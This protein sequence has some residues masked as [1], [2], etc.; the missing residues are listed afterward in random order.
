M[1]DLHTS[2]FDYHLPEELI[3]DHP[4]DRRDEARLIHLLREDQSIRHVHIFDLPSLLRPGDLLVVNDT[5]VIPAR[6][7]GRRAPGGGRVEVLLVRPHAPTTTE[8][9]G[10]SISR[11][12]ALVRPGKKIRPGD[13]LVFD[14]DRLEA[15]VAGFAEGPGA[16]LLDFCWHGDSWDEVLEAIGKT[17]LPPYILRR[18]QKGH[19]T[20]PWD[21]DLTTAEDRERYQTVYAR[22]SG[23]V[24]APTAGLHFTPEVLRELDRHGIERASVTLHVG[25]GTFQPVETENPA[26]HP[27]H[28]EDY[29]ISEDAAER[30]ERAREDGRRIVGVGTTVVRVLEHVASA[31]GRIVPGGGS[32][33]LLVLPGYRFK[34]IGALLT[35]FHLPLSTLLM[36]V[37]AFAGR[38]FVLR[39]YDEAVRQ[40][41]RF[42]SYGDAMLIE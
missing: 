12:E 7:L 27:M 25:P 30:I 41:Y 31:K 22:V 21:D 35:N 19:V 40:Q 17:P 18:R 5:R 6:L 9:S 4:A 37:A 23:S 24:A 1:G 34:V 29:E 36:L 14:P 26:E 15:V 2:D 13:R 28:E 42:Y 3:A 10:T 39:A 20:Y 38:E 11:W 8:E 32:T 33:R 16:R